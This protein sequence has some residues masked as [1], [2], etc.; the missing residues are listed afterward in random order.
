MN[1]YL[2]SLTLQLLFPQVKFWCAICFFCLFHEG[3]MTT[4]VTIADLTMDLQDGVRMTAPHLEVFMTPIWIDA[5]LLAETIMAM[6]AI[7]TEAE[8]LEDLPLGIYVLKTK[9]LFHLEAL[10]MHSGT[11]I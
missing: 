6:V 8:V 4:A 11:C 2:A 1:I 9:Y 10:Y 3:M 7:H 5:L